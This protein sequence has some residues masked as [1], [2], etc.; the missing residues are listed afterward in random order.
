VKYRATPDRN[1]GLY[2]DYRFTNGPLTGFGVNVGVDYKGEVAGDQV[3]PSYTTV[4]P[5]P[6]AVK[7]VAAQPS[8]LVAARTLVNLGVSY[9]APKWIA[10]VTVTNLFDKDYIQAALNRNSLYVGDPR[11]VRASLTYKF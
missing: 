8:F 11:A 3:N 2:A 1:G 10:R 6:G 7:F 4:K 9:R 5:L